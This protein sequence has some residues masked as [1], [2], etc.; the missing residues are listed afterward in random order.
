MA[1]T[2][3]QQLGCPYIKTSINNREYDM[4]IDSGAEICAISE[5]YYNNIIQDDSKI[6]VIPLTGLSI[7]N[8]M[9]NKPTKV[10]KQILLPI[11]IGNEQIQTP[12]IVINNLNEKGIMGSDFLE[13]NKSLIDYEKRQLTIKI[14][15]NMY[16]IP[17]S[18]KETKQPV[19]LRAICTQP[20]TEPLNQIQFNTLPDHIQEKLDKLVQQYHSVFRNIPGE[21]KGYECVIRLKDDKPV[22]Q[23]PYPIPITKREAVE[24]EV[25]RMLDM[26][27]IKQSRSPYSVPIVPV[28]KKNGDVRLCLDARKINEQ[29]I[30][31]RECPMTIE[32]IFSK[33]EKI[34]CISTL[35]LRSG[36]WQVKLA[37]KSMD[38]CSF[39]ING[40]NYSFKRLPFGLNISGSEFQKSMDI[41]LGPLLQSFVT[42]Y[43][44]DILITSENESS[45]YE[46]IKM[47]L[48]RFEKYN[49]TINIDKCQF[50]RKQVSFLGHIISTEGIKM[51]TDKI[52]TIQD[53]KTPSKKKEI[54]SYLGFLNFYRKYVK[55]F[56]HIIEPLIELT[57]NNVKWKWEEKHQRAFEESKKAFLNDVIIMFPDFSKPLY[58]NTDA[59]N[60]AIGG[61]LYQILDN[62]ERATL[63]YASRT[64]KSPETRYTTTEIEALA[65][66][67][68]CNKFRQY[69]VG[70]KTIIQTDHHALT[71]MKSCRLTNGRLTRWTLALQEYD[72]EIQYIPG[73]DNIVADTL[74]RYP[75]INEEREEV[76]ISINKI[77]KAEYSVE[78]RKLIENLAKLQQSDIKLK[79]I[80]NAKNEYVKLNENIVFVKGKTENNWR[81]VIPGQI[82]NRLTQETHEIMGHP[83]RYKTYHAL[84]GICIFKNMHKIAALIV[85][86]CDSCQ[87]SK[88]IN[89]QSSGPTKSHK[90]KAPFE[91]V[92]IDL[93]GPLPTGRGGT[94][95]ILAIL[96]TF[97]KFIRLYA[98]K[99]A[100]AKAI[101]N[102]LEFDYI[103]KTGK[104][105]SILTDNGTQFTGKLWKTKL[106]ELNIIIK[107]STKYHPQSN[108]VERYNREIGRLLRTY[109]FDQHTKWPNYLEKI[110]E[111][112]NKVRSEVTE[113]TPWEIIKGEIPKQ[114]LEEIINFP[115]REN[116]DKKKEEIVQMVASR[117]KK[118]AEKLESKQKNKKNV[119]YEIGQHVLIKNHDLSNAQNKEI[120]KLF[121]I[122]NGPVIV[123]R[124][125]SQNTLAVRNIDS[126]RE[127]LVNV[128]EVRPYY[129]M[130][131]QNID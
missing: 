100:S 28:F 49:V 67:Y 73:K 8:A 81:V 64:L 61:E 60:V 56:A 130:D 2:K 126:E 66:V 89:Y 26:G 109:C 12:F 95:Y 44:D 19:H 78:L 101:I 63:G 3:T 129:G 90:P 94:H 87:R 96:D 79:R 114:P 29:I 30:P 27:I 103:P 119:K 62:N 69:I 125:V 32:T 82:A 31:D 21:I 128:S 33:F 35:D 51:D 16:D 42:I 85:R 105:Q 36:Y 58:I 7:H 113:M 102:R 38:P 54:Q 77:K 20:I 1:F 121:H 41:V 106:H 117:I 57:R 120:K 123:T 98:L 17:F 52:K 15:N 112:M 23:R 25:K 50:F 55:K 14:N 107:H 71:F 68:C 75:R 76:S 99:R 111:W 47:V 34:K 39:L 86:N 48:E 74:T 10:T 72:L 104:P 46:H 4:L 91:T 11:E 84:K 70:H 124:I 13:T 45:H 127:E 108:P 53:F 6:P 97:S 83:G 110:E 22:N 43:V 24:K 65:L 118:K 131:K 5:E 88:P 80:I 59:S 37:E 18:E 116:K 115:E 92:S 40:R 9:G 93:M 122:F